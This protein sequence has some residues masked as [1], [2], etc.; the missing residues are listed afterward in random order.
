MLRPLFTI[1][2]LAPALFLVPP[3]AGEIAYVTLVSREPDDAYRKV[4]D[5]VAA[6]EA[7]KLGL[8]VAWRKVESQSELPK[9]FEEIVREAEILLAVRIASS[10]ESLHN[11][12]LTK[13]PPS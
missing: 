7:N 10:P 1:A 11:L 5:I 3:H 4:A 8:E 12:L 13:L 2:V 9:A 6:T